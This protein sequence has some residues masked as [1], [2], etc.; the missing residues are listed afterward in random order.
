MNGR[1]F[2]FPDFEFEIFLTFSGAI[3]YHAFMSGLILTNS[4]CFGG[5]EKF[6]DDSP[7]CTLH[8]P[9]SCVVR[10]R[11]SENA[12]GEIYG[13]RSLLVM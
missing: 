5:S 10:I 7:V 3:L 4:V 9:R 8:L 2:S 6:V 12:T 11:K 13:N 1:S